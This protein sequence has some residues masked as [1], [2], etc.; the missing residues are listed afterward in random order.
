MRLKSRT[1]KGIDFYSV[2][3]NGSSAKNGFTNGLQGSNWKRSMTMTRN[4]AKYGKAGIGVL[5]AVLVFSAVGVLAWQGVSSN[6]IKID[7]SFEDWQGVEKT[8]R[9]RDL[10]VP[11]NIDIAEYA[12]AES[13]KNVAFYAKVYGNL[14]V[15]DGR[16][17]VEAPSENPVYV[18]YQRET[19][20][21]NQNGRDVA[22]V[23]VDT[24][25]NAATGF[26]PSVNFAVGADKSI[27]IVG[28][29]GKIEA[30]RVLTFAGVVQQEWTWVIG[31]SVA[32]ATNGKQVETMAG[33]SLLGIGEN[34][35]VYFYMIDWQNKEC[36]LENALQYVNPDNFML[37]ERVLTAKTP[38]V[39]PVI[40]SRGTVH[41]PIHING[42]AD[43]ASQ[44]LSEGW[45]GDG[46]ENAP[47]LIEGYDI[48]SAGGSYGIWIE[49]TTVHFAVRNCTIQGATSIS[50]VPFGAAIALNNVQNGKIENNTCTASIRGVYIYGAS[51]YNTIVNNTANT[52]QQGIA[53]YF[54]DNNTIVNNSANSNTYGIYLYYASN[55]VV[56]FC[57]ANSNSVSG[58]YVGSS[59]NITIS[60][61]NANGNT[62]GITLFSS[63][64]A[65][66]NTN[67]V[68]GNNYGIYLSQAH[69]NN[70][71]FNT[72][73]NNY[74]G[75]YIQFSNYNNIAYNNFS[76]NYYYGML[77]HTSTNH[78]ITKNILSNNNENGLY[79]TYYSNYNTITENN[80]SGNSNGTY[81]HRST[82]NTI[83]LNWFCN[84]V[85]YGV[86][87]TD[88]STNNKINHNYFI[89]N[90][91]TA[92][93]YLGQGVSNDTPNGAG[94]GVSGNCQAYDDVGGNYWYDNSVNE[95]NYWSNWDGNGNGTAN[96]YPIDGGAGASDWYP[97]GSPVSE[98]SQLSLIAL[99]IISMLGFWRGTL[100][101][102]PRNTKSQLHRRTL[103]STRAN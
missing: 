24:D 7:G 51:M 56:D 63:N 76:G 102:C 11:E 103:D 69:Y 6:V 97:M 4:R 16:Y 48:N 94:K 90:R 18:A 85:K 27:E 23:F 8:T 87:L 3:K 100:Y 83:T 25:N 70:I 14:L 82:N 73:Y 41:A 1:T 67:L 93:W 47:Y 79:L 92:L 58:I 57:N 46:T 13:G 77:L 72:G 88:M 33:K 28:K 39:T 49:N 2:R 50:T 36:K 61:T 84:N 62:Y 38:T 9:A 71:T 99:L 29:N 86:Y 66:I 75:A 60:N 19:A 74:D 81:L 89:G 45:S 21:P 37:A 101:K 68:N 35:A 43:F 22:Y 91:A 64:N 65:T 96:A 95:G 5:F 26:K 12:T 98:C 44:A 10:G 80:V 52:V 34:Y 31:E 54:S 53:L 32:A 15:G 55:V 78:T 40:A 42:D 17:I 59:D 20:I 30:C